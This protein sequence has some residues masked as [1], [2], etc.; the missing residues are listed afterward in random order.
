MMVRIE[1]V[2]KETESILKEVLLKNRIDV[3]YEE[4]HVEVIS[5]GLV[6]E[7]VTVEETQIPPDVHDTEEPMEIEAPKIVSVEEKEILAE[8]VEVPNDKKKFV[9]MEIVVEE[10][11]VEVKEV[12]VE[13]RDIVEAVKKFL[14]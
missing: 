2:G 13:A 4:E 7:E 6:N 14:E 10:K 11:K 1:E 3:V 9:A 12:S 5:F 8:E